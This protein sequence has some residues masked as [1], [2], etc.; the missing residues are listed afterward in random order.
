VLVFI[1]ACNGHGQKPAPPVGV[2][3]E[4]AQLRKQL[5]SSPASASLHGQLAAMLAARGDWQESDRE[6]GVA[7][8][9][10]PDDAMLSIEA[11]QGYRVRGMADKAI[12]LLKHSIEIDS[13]NPLT[14]FNLALIYE[15]RH[16]SEAATAEF[17]ETERLIND[18]SLPASSP[19]PR[20]RIIKGTHGEIWYHDQFGKDYLLNG[21]VQPLQKKLGRGV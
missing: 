11:A 21:I 7:M 20:N 1:L 5:E 2:E 13:K 8:Q 19:D 10:D 16:D 12:A 6:M 9:L 14:H 4:I 3:D 17:R 18:L 15:P